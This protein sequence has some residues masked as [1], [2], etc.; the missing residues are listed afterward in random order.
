MGLKPCAMQGAGHIFALAGPCRNVAARSGGEAS[1]EA[2]HAGMNGGTNDSLTLVD[3]A[4]PVLTSV[5]VSAYE[6]PRLELVESDLAPP[7]LSALALERQRGIV[8]KLENVTEFMAGLLVIVIALAVLWFFERQLAKIEALYSIAES[9]CVSVKEQRPDGENES[10]HFPA[11]NRRYHGRLVHVSGG[12]AVPTGPIVDPWFEHEKLTNTLRLRTQVEVYQWIEKKG[13]IE[14]YCKEWSS[15]TNIS[16]SFQDQTKVNT[17][18][19]GITIGATTTN[20]DSADYGEKEPIA[21]PP[22]LVDQMEGFQ[23]AAEFLGPTVTSRVGNHVFKKHDKDGVF[24]HRPTKTGASFKAEDVAASPE[25]GDA[26][27]RF[28]RVPAGPATILGLQVEKGVKEGAKQTLL[29]YRLIRRGLC[30]AVGA[31]QEREDLVAEGHKSRDQLARDN[32]CAGCCC[33]PRRVTLQGFCGCSCDCLSRVCAGAL[34]AE[35]YRCFK[36]HLTVEQSFE[37][38][39]KSAPVSCR[40]ASLFRILGWLLLIWGIWMSF[41]QYFRLDGQSEKS[42]PLI[43]ELGGWARDVFCVITA[44]AAWALIVSAAYFDYRPVWSIVWFTV[45]CVLALIPHV[46]CISHSNL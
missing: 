29:P 26:L 44:L 4:R 18:P 40:V 37:E 3:L 6:A 10:L 12:E 22:G 43:L 35:V 38:V 23:T 33:L 39:R 17:F 8:R 15:I 13:G 25:I 21:L 42:D 20:C 24:Y 31:E 27:V 16:G 1:S 32:R 19:S 2:P 41:G 14:P 36:G 11:G 5:L 30:G 45:G 9:T 28:Q 46:L 34:T 7:E